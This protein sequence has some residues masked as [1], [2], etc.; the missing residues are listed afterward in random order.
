[1]TPLSPL[2]SVFFYQLYFFKEIAP[3]IWL[4]SPLRHLLLTPTRFGSHY[5]LHFIS[6]KVI[7]SDYTSVWMSVAMLGFV[8]VG[9]MEGM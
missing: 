3:V 8:L 9:H 2:R 4:F 6:T 1:M 5:S 7:Q